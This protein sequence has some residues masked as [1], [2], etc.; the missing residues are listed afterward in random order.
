[1]LFGLIYGRLRAYRMQ[2]TADANFTKMVIL[3]ARRLRA[4]GYSMKTLL[5]VF[6]KA[7]NQLLSS[8]PRRPALTRPE[9]GVTDATPVENPLIFHLKHHPRGVTRQQ[10]RQAYSEFIAPILPDR[11]LVIAVSRPKNIRDQVCRTRLQDVPGDNPSD[12]IESGDDTM[13]P[14]ILPRR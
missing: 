4:R 8:N 14:Q 7:G 13:S 1:M 12:Y 10:V 5:P 11:P 6:Q 3:L 2:N 9:T